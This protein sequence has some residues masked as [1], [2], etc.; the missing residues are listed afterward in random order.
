ML[1]RRLYNYPSRCLRS[2]PR[3]PLRKTLRH[4]ILAARPPLN[5]RTART[6]HG[7]RS[8]YIAKH[9]KQ[10]STLSTSFSGLEPYSSSLAPPSRP[11]IKLVSAPAVHRREGAF[12]PSKI[13]SSPPSRHLAQS[14]ES[15]QSPPSIDEEP[16][17][18]KLPRTESRPVV[19]IEQ[20]ESSEEAVPARRAAL[21]LHRESS[22]VSLSEQTAKR[23][24]S[25]N[26]KT[27]AL[28]AASLS[29]SPSVSAASSSSSVSHLPSL[30]PKS[31]RGGSDEEKQN[32]LA[33]S[34][35]RAL[36]NLKRFSSLPRTPSRSSKSSKRSSSPDARRS[37][38]PPLPPPPHIHVQSPPRRRV[39][40]KP[41]YSHPWPPAMSV[42]EVVVL[43]AS[44]DRAKAYAM[45][46]NELAMYDCGLRDWM[47]SQGRGSGKSCLR[48]PH[49]PMYLFELNVRDLQSPSPRHRR[50]VRRIM[51]LMHRY[52]QSLAG[53]LR[54]HAIYLTVPWRPRQHS[55]S[56]LT[57]IQQPICQLGPAISRQV[58]LRLRF[59]H[60]P[61]L[62][63][64]RYSAR[65]YAPPRSSCHRQSRSSPFPVRKVL[66]QA[67]LRPSVARPA[68]ARTSPRSLRLDRSHHPQIECSRNSARPRLLCRSQHPNLLAQRRRPP[69]PPRSPADPVPPL[70]AFSV[71]RHTPL[72]RRSRSM[73]PPRAPRDRTRA[74]SVRRRR[75]S[76]RS[77]RARSARA[78]A[79][80][81]RALRAGHLCSRAPARGTPRLSPRARAGWR[82]G[83]TLAR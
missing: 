11:S 62:H 46:I 19:V 30:P 65:P 26:G 29:R 34:A 8:L 49:Q 78:Q 2:S 4:P 42:A 54:S 64:R 43:K 82:A 44:R 47:A 9:Q 3:G 74:P 67:S 68:F 80:A 73:S 50:D 37:L 6:R 28:Q 5:G 60:T 51:P 41:K 23:H 25:P 40:P 27:A 72:G 69:L 14:P 20:D 31:I 59:S 39:P 12:P 57:R 63:R 32:T 53:C 16:P 15:F 10:K 70:G 1:S 33:P 22:W 21:E 79:R 18:S 17:A 77:R 83:R 66:A 81:R 55:P 35:F 76:S 13:L 48:C 71:R 61:P 38:S 36:T 7:V 24:S 52:Q 58:A 45:K 56:A 75:D